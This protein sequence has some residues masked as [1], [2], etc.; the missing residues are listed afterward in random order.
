MPNPT[1]SV[2]VDDAVHSE[3]ERLKNELD[4]ST[5][6]D[7]LRHELGIVP[8]AKV[9]ELAAFLSDELRDAAHDVV[10]VIESVN[11]FTKAVE[12]GDYG[13]TYLTFT[14]VETDRKIASIGFDEEEFTVSYMNKD[15]EMDQCGRGRKSSSGESQYGTTSGTYDHIAR[16][17]VLNNVEDKVTGSNRRWGTE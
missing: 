3:L 13:K 5:F 8:E 9:D 6:N 10:D 15:G 2:K 12:E 1:N 4:V 17:E 7:A 14:S 11:G 16:E